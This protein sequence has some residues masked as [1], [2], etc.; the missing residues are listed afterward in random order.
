MNKKGFTLLELLVVVLIIGILSAVA[1]PRYQ[2][3]VE[4]SRVTQAIT[5]LKA[6]YDAQKV[7][8]MANGSYATSFDELGIEI[9]WAGNTALWPYPQFVKDTRSNNDW[10][11]QLYQNE[12]P[13]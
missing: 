4:K 1:L 13:S 6:V 3:A 7:Y 5:L 9:P 12:Y 11:F 8:Y 10:S 2:K